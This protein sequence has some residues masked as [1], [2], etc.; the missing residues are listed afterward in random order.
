MKD[1]HLRSISLAPI[2][3]ELTPCSN[4]P[5]ATIHTTTAEQQLTDI[6][7]TFLASETKRP[8]G[9]VND[10][11]RLPCVLFGVCHSLVVISTVC[12]LFHLP[13]SSFFVVPLM[14][15]VQVK[16]ICCSAYRFSAVHRLHSLLMHVQ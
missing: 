1:R 4:S 6:L 10:V 7:T 14:A 13:P 8:V 11:T 5:Y 16:K 12:S 15:P 9:I 3:F 2:P